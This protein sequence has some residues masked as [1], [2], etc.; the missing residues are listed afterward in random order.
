MLVADDAVDHNEHDLVD[1]KVVGG[2][3]AGDNHFA[4]APRGVDHNLGAVAVGG[5][6]GHGHARGVRVDH[7]LNGYRDRESFARNLVGLAVADGARG[8]EAGPALANLLHYVVLA[9]NPEV[10]VL[11]AGERGVGQVFGGRTRAHGYGNLATTELHEFAISGDNLVA[12]GIG[13]LLG[14]DELADDGGL[15]IDL[16]GAVVVQALEVPGNLIV[17]RGLIHHRVER[18]GGHRE[19]GRNGHARVRHDDQRCALAAQAIV[20]GLFGAVKRE[21]IKRHCF[22]FVLRGGK[23]TSYQVT[24]T[25]RGTRNDR[26]SPN[27]MSAPSVICNPGSFFVSSSSATRTWSFPSMLPMQ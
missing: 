24:G 9:L 19:S 3:F 21:G 7:L 10:R 8:V 5:V 14:E 25:A 23:G 15:T 1:H 12:H 13:N 26:L 27:S 20:L 18:V 11:L 16:I 6:D 22:P 17:Q 2:H 4:Q